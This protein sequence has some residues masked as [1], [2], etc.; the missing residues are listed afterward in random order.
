MTASNQNSAS[1]KE[2]LFV[3]YLV[4]LIAEIRKATLCFKIWKSI[5]AYIEEYHAELNQAPAFWNSARTAYLDTTLICLCRIVD[6]HKD[7]L[8]IWKLLNYVD[9]NVSIFSTEA[10][11][12]RMTNNVGYKQ[13]L[14]CYRPITHE[15]I[16]EDRKTMKA[17]HPTI[18]H[19]MKWRRKAIAHID[20]Q[21]LNSKIHFATKYPIKPRDIDTLIMTT[22]EVLNRYSYAYNSSK[23]VIDI[24][25]ESGLQAILESIR[26]KLKETRRQR[27]LKNRKES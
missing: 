2:R 18:D 13:L 1:N 9:A 5:N 24:P 21:A 3:S 10:F 15:L 25:F 20:L 27:G 17:L 7:S 8:S 23:W 19:L 12:E 6:E 11:S 14:K 16:E 4:K 22:T 26:F